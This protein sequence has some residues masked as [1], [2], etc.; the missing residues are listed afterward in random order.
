[1]EYQSY[2]NLPFLTQMGRKD[3]TVHL[4]PR[5][6]TLMKLMNLTVQHLVSG[7]LL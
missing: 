2:Q 1:M 3:E 6:K 5:Q 4:H 7:Q